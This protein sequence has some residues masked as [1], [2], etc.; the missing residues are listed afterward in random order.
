MDDRIQ[1]VSIVGA[2]LMLLAV[3]ELVR[4]R[5]FLERY[6]LTWIGAAVILLILA[7]WRSGLDKIANGLGIAYPPN[8]LFLVA[9]AFI[10][11]LLLNFS[12]AVSR[13][14]D[15][16]KVLAQRVAI[17]EERLRR[18]EAPPA[19]AAVAEAVQ[20]AQDAEQRPTQP[21]V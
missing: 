3:L 9:G 15:Q 21:R 1:I 4:R 19:S 18:V 7:S 5:R 11:L 16:S 8:A 13:L 14:T 20:Q 12:L 6:A 10:L 17:L 2:A